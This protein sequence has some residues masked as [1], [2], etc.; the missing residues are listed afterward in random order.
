MI[1]WKVIRINLSVFLHFYYKCP[2]GHA[3][4]DSMLL[5]TP[6]SNIYMRSISNMCHSLSAV[7][8]RHQHHISLLSCIKC[9]RLAPRQGLNLVNFIDIPYLCHPSPPSDLLSDLRRTNSRATSSLVL[10]DNILR[11]VPPVSSTCSL[12]PRA[13]HEAQLPHSTM[14][15]SCITPIPINRSSRA[16]Q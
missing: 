11:I 14:S 8:R 9:I 16:K 12:R 5:T 1:K 7:H 6:F 10:W 15:L 3:K 13:H 2:I 4:G